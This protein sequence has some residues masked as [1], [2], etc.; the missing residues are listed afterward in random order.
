[1][2]ACRSFCPP[3]QA[4][5]LDDGGLREYL[6]HLQQG[7]FSTFAPPAELESTHRLFQRLAL[8]PNGAPPGPGGASG[9][10]AAAAAANGARGGQGEA[11]GPD[12]P[13]VQRQQQRQQPGREPEPPQQ[14]LQQQQ[15]APYAFYGSASGASSLFHPDYV[16]LLGACA[17]L[18]WLQ[19]EGLHEVR[20]GGRGGGASRCC[21]VC[22]PARSRDAAGFQRLAPAV[23]HA[24]QCHTPS[25]LPAC[26]P[27]R[28]PAC[29]WWQ[30]W[31]DASL[32]PSARCPTGTT[33]PSRPAWLGWRRRGR[34]CGEAVGWRRAGAAASAGRR[35]MQ[36]PACCQ[37]PHDKLR[38]VG[39]VTPASLPAACAARARRVSRA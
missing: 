8:P 33:P 9:A 36:A 22:S 15:Q 31:S 12:A 6:A 32:P 16:A 23:Q 4:A 26:L 20:R 5:Q 25:A 1:M 34:C 29:R 30:H 38:L 2:G 14:V 37:D 19:P 3:F 17:P 18:V 28:P 27:A 10:A 21:A 13:A 7:L 39:R 24:G 35:G 11:P